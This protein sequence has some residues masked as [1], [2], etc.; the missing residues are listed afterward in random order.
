MDNKMKFS[1]IISRI[2]C[3]NCKGSGFIKTKIIICN[4]CCGATCGYCNK[5]GHIQGPWTICDE[6]NGDGE[7]VKYEVN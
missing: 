7:F 2:Q 5:K 6:C 4:N 1:S 3:V